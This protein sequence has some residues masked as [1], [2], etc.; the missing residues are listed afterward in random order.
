MVVAQLERDFG[1]VLIAAGVASNGT[2]LELIVSPARTWTMLITLPNG[3]SCFGAAGEMWTE[4]VPED[5][6]PAETDR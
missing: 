2:I 6:P 4:A 1:E 5:E 3:T